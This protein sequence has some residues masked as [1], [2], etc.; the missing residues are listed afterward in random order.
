MDRFRERRAEYLRLTSDGPTLLIAPPAAIRT[1]DVEYPYRPDN[2]LYYLTGFAEPE[3][4]LLLLPGEPSRFILFVRSR[5]PEREAWDGPR[6]GLDGAM[7]QY[8]ADESHPFD[9]LEA[10]L[11]RAVEGFDR[12][13]F[14]FGKHPS[15]DRRVAEWLARYRT[16]R[17]GG[18]HA[19][20]ALIDAAEVLHELR[21]RKDEESIRHLRRAADISAD[22][23]IAAMREARA[24]VWE[25]QLAA[26]VEFEFARRGATWG[27]PSIVG[28]GPNATTLHYTLNRRRML[29]GDLVL[30]DAGAEV[31]CLTADVTRTFPVN[32]RFSLAQREIYE[33]VLEAEER[34][35]R[36]AIPGASFNAPHEVALRTLVEGMLRLG[37]L[38]GDL[39]EHLQG[40]AYRR[41]FMHRTSHWLGMDVHDVGK[42]KLD[43][44]WRR[45]EPGMVLTVEPGLYIPA[46]D[47][48][49]P[50]DYRGIG[51]RIEDDVFVTSAG[52]EVLTAGCPKSPAEIEKTC[53]QAGIAK[54]EE[55]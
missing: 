28:S 18:V 29:D 3:S 36:A 40:T 33:L 23:H 50:T 26:R 41:Y 20:C 19:P 39:E 25:Y 14:G 49:A 38:S 9:E 34:A 24:G 43:G 10:H 54:R 5:D 53:L 17:R 7:E 45:L 6:A 8:G 51:I 42:Y 22:A 52:P 16:R 46:E 27:Y 32:G 44:S 30:I 2:D 1:G 35:I 47:M 4:A 37:L 13:Y 15:F 48:E 12:L 55:T 11:P 21:L 31:E